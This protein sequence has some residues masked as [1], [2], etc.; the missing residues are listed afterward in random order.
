MDDFRRWKVPELKAY[1]AKRGVGTSANKE[2]LVHIAL[3][4][5]KLIILSGMKAVQEE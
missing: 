1:L 3:L 5:I 4:K 2:E